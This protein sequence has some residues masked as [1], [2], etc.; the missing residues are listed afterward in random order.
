MWSVRV[1]LEIKTETQAPSI[2]WTFVNWKNHLEQ[3]IQFPSQN[4]VKLLWIIQGRR[5]LETAMAE[6]N[7]NRQKLCCATTHDCFKVIYPINGRVVTRR[8]QLG[9]HTAIDVDCTDTRPACSESQHHL[10]TIIQYSLLLTVWTATGIRCSKL[11][12]DHNYCEGWPDD[13]GWW[14]IRAIVTITGPSGSQRRLS[15]TSILK[16]SWQWFFL[17]F[18]VGIHRASIKLRN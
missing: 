6:L 10:I 13:T 15:S 8:R 9:S 16:L 4:K 18:F 2:N 12:C 7:S 5:H 3:L 17:Q 1:H 14:G 11:F